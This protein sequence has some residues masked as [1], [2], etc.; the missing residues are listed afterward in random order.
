MSHPHYEPPHQDLCCWQIQLFSSVVL[1]ELKQMQTVYAQTRCTGAVI[2]NSVFEFFEDQLLHNSISNRLYNH[3]YIRFSHDTVQ[4]A[5]ISLY[6]FNNS[7]CEDFSYL[8]H[9]ISTCILL[10]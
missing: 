4:I 3:L 9:S 7:I 2:F 6:A 1:K 10:D 5:E 8:L